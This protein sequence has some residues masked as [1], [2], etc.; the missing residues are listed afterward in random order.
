MKQEETNK[1]AQKVEEAMNTVAKTLSDAKLPVS[2]I[3]SIL[4]VLKFDVIMNSGVV[5][6]G[7]PLEQ[8]QEVKKDD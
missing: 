1:Q 6:R 8:A 3:I 4:E 5:E 7:K 2:D